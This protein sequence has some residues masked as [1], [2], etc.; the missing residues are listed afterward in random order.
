M[1]LMPPAGSRKRPAPGTSPLLQQQQQHLTN[2]NAGTLQMPADP[3]I[4]WN[5]P[6]LTS[7]SNSYADPSIA[8]GSN[9]Y[10]G[11][12]QQDTPSNTASTQIARRAG[13][14]HV[15]PRRAYNNGA[16]ESWSLVS[17]DT[18]PQSQDSAWLNTADDLEQKAQI[19]RRDTQAKR[20]QIPPFVQKLSR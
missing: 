19:A 2:I 12:V 6:D 16:D 11:S 5:Q 14:H 8:F 9:M 20:K 13:N 10:N 15:V 7:A 18:V 1:I 3:N 17:E 4:Q